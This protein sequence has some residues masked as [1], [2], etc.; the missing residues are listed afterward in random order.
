LNALCNDRKNDGSS[1]NINFSKRKITST[2]N[3]MPKTV[4]SISSTNALHLPQISDKKDLERN[5]SVLETD[6]SANEDR[7]QEIQANQHEHARITHNTRLIDYMKNRAN[8]K[9][10]YLAE[11]ESK[12]YS[13][14]DGE[15]ADRKMNLA[16]LE[17]IVEATTKDIETLNYVIPKSSLASLWNIAYNSRTFQGNITIYH[18]DETKAKDLM[19]K[20]HENRKIAEDHIK[21]LENNRA[22]ALELKAKYLENDSSSTALSEQVQESLPSSSTSGVTSST[23]SQQPFKQNSTDVHK[24]EFDPCDYYDE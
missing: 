5:V 13:A 1:K 20:Y 10:Q 3:N 2:N 11:Q 21:V 24:T 14:M 6:Y 9:D 17:S 16:R 12:V 19:A 23:P 4:R 22:Q 7:L 15:D 18:N 8:D